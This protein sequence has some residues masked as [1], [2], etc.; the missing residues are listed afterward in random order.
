MDRFAHSKQNQLQSD[1]RRVRSRDKIALLL[2]SRGGERL[3]RC[4]ALISRGTVSS[5]DKS[6]H[7]TSTILLQMVCGHLDLW[8]WF[9]F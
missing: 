9:S 8:P 1:V 7:L 6:M 3:A 2:Y 5:V 4:I